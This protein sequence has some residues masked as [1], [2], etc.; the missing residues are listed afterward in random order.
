MR[1]L[2]P[3][4]VKSAARLLLLHNMI[5]LPVAGTANRDPKIFG[6][7][8]RRCRDSPFADGSE[9]RV[10]L[11]PP[12]GSWISS[13]RINTDSF[14]RMVLSNDSSDIV[15]FTMRY[16][17]FNLMPFNKT[18]VAL[19][20]L[21]STK[22]MNTVALSSPSGA[23]S[24]TRTGINLRCVPVGSRARAAAHSEAA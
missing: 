21:R 9:G 7:Q 14:I 13:G 12:L 20:L 3:W 2:P 11:F 4:S 1:T 23:H 17:P 10:I 15:T 24:R 18:L 6:Y 19:P 8:I 5:Q 16:L 22:S